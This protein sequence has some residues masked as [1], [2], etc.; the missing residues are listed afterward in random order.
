MDDSKRISEALP[1]YDLAG[2]DLE[3]PLILKRKGEPV[4]VV[5]SFEEYRRLRAIEA[6][7]ELKRQIA[8]RELEQLLADIHSRPTDFT[9]EQIEQEITEARAEV[10]RKRR[11]ARSGS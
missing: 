5:I 2:A 9:P 3:Q 6:S 1:S 8:G 10:R 7:E 11:A 4:A